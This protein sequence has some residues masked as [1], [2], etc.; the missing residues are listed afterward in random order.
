MSN[1]IQL[2]IDDVALPTATHDRYQAYPEDLTVDVQMISGRE[3]Q[4]ARGTV[5]RI[6]YSYDYMGDDKC[7]EVLGVLR[8]SGP[9]TVTFLPDNSDKLVTSKFKVTS[10]TNPTLAFFKGGVPKWHNFGFVLREV[11]PHA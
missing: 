9:K 4:E 7:R 10:I 5:W 11:K 8:R 6:V 1:P 2:I 3:P